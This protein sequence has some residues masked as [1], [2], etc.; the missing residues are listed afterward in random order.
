MNL[1]TIIILLVV[2]TLLILIGVREAI[3]FE[4]NPLPKFANGDKRF[5]EIKMQ[6]TRRIELNND[7]L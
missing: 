2:S 3:R 7:L 4:R 5:G 1:I 6:K